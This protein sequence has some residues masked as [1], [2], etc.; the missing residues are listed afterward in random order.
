MTKTGLFASA[1][2]VGLLAVLAAAPTAAS[3]QQSAAAS[4]PG[5]GDAGAG[6]TVGEVTVTARLRSEPLE[7]VPGSVVAASG[8]TV[9]QLN[10]VSLTEISQIAPGV[11]FVTD[12]GRFGSGPAISVRGISTFTQSGAIQDSVGILLDGV[13]LSRAKAGAFPDLRDIDQIEVLRGPQGTLFGKNSDAGVI[14]I[15]TRDP[16]NSFTG[17][18]AVDYSTYN[19]RVFHGSVSGPLIDDKLLGIASFYSETRDGYINDIYNDT[20]WGNDNQLGGRAK[21]VYMPTS[22]DR[23]KLSA[24]YLVENDDAGTET[25]RSFLSTTPQYIVTALSP[26]VGNDNAQI[27]S[28]SVGANGRPSSNLQRTGGLA[29][30]WDHSIGGYTLT[31]ITGYRIFTQEADAGTY[32]WPTPLNDGDTTTGVHTTQYS[33]ELRISSPDTGRL[34]YV[35]GAFVYHDQIRSYLYDPNPGLLVLSSTGVPNPVRQQRNWNN[36]AQSL[37]Y[38]A[39][40]E[41]DYDVIQNLTLTAGFR[42]THENDDVIINGLPVTPGNQQTVVPLGTTTGSTNASDIT[43]RTAGK[44]RFAEDKMFYVSAATGFKGPG[45]NTV[46][47]ILGDPQRVIPETSIS[48]EAGIK[49]QFLDKR[50]TFNLTGFYAT[51]RN[52]QTQGFSLAPGT[53][54]AQV[55]LSNA[56]NLK[57]QGVESEFAWRVAPDTTL[58]ANATYIDATF[59]SFPGAQCY[60]TQ[61]S[62]PGQCVNGEQNLTGK[63]LANTPKWAFNAAGRHDFAIPGVTWSGFVTAD[64]SWHSSIQWDVLQNP[65]AI[66]A[67][68]GLLGASVGLQSPDGKYVVKLYGK[69]LGDQFHTE[70]ILVGQVIYQFLPVDYRRVIGIDL[71]AKF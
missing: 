46:S 42:A 57:T 2:V 25:V 53:T 19:D 36:Q 8:Q 51:Y 58:T 38:A 10:M 30:Q 44:W 9:A 59:G 34:R 39:F 26:I 40:G 54:V 67:G 64:Y 3:A 15:K 17:D 62:G 13:P 18:G 50:I 14:S 4:S 63:P 1:A 41:A 71:A 70:G 7:N 29:L 68:Y 55:L 52:F 66:E 37:N 22:A 35:A 60:A 24:D 16:T 56:A 5:A 43:W 48:Y 11:T 32:S 45:F 21:L 49:T 33:S 6:S 47:S 20:K 69:N 31:S 65:L 23:I 28:K 12:P 61:V 27:D